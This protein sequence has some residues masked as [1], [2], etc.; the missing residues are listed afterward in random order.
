MTVLE[1]AFLGLVQGLSEFLPISSS[2]H[3]VVAQFLFGVRSSQLAFG[4]LVH[5]ATLMALIFVFRRRLAGLVARRDVDYLGKLA[6]GTVPIAIIGLSFEAA[7]ERAFESIWLVAG[8]LAVTGT[9]LLSLYRLPDR[10]RPRPTVPGWSGAL[11]I[12][13]VQAAALLPGVSRSGTTIVAGLWLGLAPA[14]AA[15]FSFLLGIPAI[16]GA[17]L[18]E[19]GA[20]RTAA[21]GG[22]GTEMVAGAVVAFLSGFVAIAVV[23]RLLERDTFRRFGFYCWSVAAGVATWLLVA[24]TG[25]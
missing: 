21:G 9:A 11:L 17:L 10:P 1:A 23:F 16:A 7:V 18:I 13:L 25:G 20:L 4:V 2:G 22:L 24:G 6:L 19:L 5:G 12:G 3:L 14:A 8:C 15:E